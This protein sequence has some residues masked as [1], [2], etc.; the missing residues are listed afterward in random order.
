VIDIEQK[1]RPFQPVFDPLYGYIPLSKAEF[2]IVRSPLFQRLGQIRQLGFAHVLFPSATHTRLSHSLGVLRTTQRM[3]HS[4]NTGDRSAKPISPR[5]E[6]LLRFAALLHDIGHLPLSHVGEKA[7]VKELS[8]KYGVVEK[9]NELSKAGTT[10]APFK[11][12]DFHE[13][14]SARIIE[15]DKEIAA[16]L[17]LFNDDI[18]SSDVIEAKHVADLLL[19]RGRQNKYGHLTPFIKSGLDADR[20]DFLMRDSYFVGS[21]YGKIEQDTLIQKLCL[22]D[23]D[24]DEDIYEL[25]LEEDAALVADHFLLSR[26]YWYSII[27]ANPRFQF[28]D[29]LTKNVMGFLLEHERMPE[30]CER[31]LSIDD[32]SR[33]TNDL[34]NEENRHAFTKFQ[35]SQVILAMRQLHE[36]WQ[37]SPPTDER[38]QEIN[39]SI[40]VLM[41]G[42]L[43]HKFHHLQGLM[44]KSDFCLIF[45]EAEIKKAEEAA[46]T[47]I[48]AEIRDFRG[49]I[50]T[51]FKAT[52]IHKALPNREPS[53]G[54]EFIRDWHG[55]VL[56]RCKKD[57]FPKC[58]PLVLSDTNLSH[59]VGRSRPKE[60]LEHPT[61]NNRA[62]THVTF[63][64]F[65]L[66]PGD[67]TV[68][69]HD[70]IERVL[71][72][73]FQSFVKPMEETIH[74]HSG[75]VAQ[76]D[77]PRV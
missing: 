9:D 58:L 55:Q 65:A 19:K 45:N 39:T 27:L 2:R 26:F 71:Y 63:A 56:I 1:L 61:D 51:V 59:R 13:Q 29:L 4:I 70:T 48:K 17:Q 72:N 16:A 31:L 49:F 44:E 28:V 32:L 8:R 6:A 15:H 23:I 37:N 62:L 10:K 68:S 66:W 41:G 50:K 74:G 35:D 76:T 33:I 12:E 38:E 22:V 24:R 73:R 77:A 60:Q 69:E 11:E 52:D 54:G 46:L 34:Q 57:L 20:L 43:S 7:Y 47:E 25:C 3:I 42:N 30:T 14:L 40:K 53:R 36:H 75:P 5:E 18:R 67:L 64:V 21:S